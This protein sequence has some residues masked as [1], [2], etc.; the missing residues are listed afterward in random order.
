MPSLFVR[1]M[2]FVS[3]YFPLTLIFSIFLIDKQRLWAI[4]ILLVGVT[5]LVAMLLYFLLVAPRRTPFHEK[6]TQLERHDGDVMSYVA[7]Y[8]IPFVTFPLDGWQQIAAILV[9]LGVLL[10]VYVNSNMIYI[11]PMLNLIGYHL[12]EVNIENNESSFYLITH[13]RVVRGATLR[14]VRIG[15]SAF[16]ETKV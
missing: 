16:L 13:H 10:V 9:F 12:Y 11:N 4:V 2:L 8:L 6:V 3:S 7:S 14:V 5:G 15:E 1:C